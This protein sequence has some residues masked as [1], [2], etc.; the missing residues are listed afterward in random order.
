VVMRPA[1][2]EFWGVW[3]LPTHNEYQRFALA[4]D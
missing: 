3:G 4:A 2:R 1:T